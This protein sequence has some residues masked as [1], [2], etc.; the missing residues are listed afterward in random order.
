ML[1][2]KKVMNFFL[3]ID[4]LKHIMSFPMYKEEEGPPCD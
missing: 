4:A 3:L 2:E 1:K